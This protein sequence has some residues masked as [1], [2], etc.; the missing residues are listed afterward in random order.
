MKRSLGT[1]FGSNAFAM[2]GRLIAYAIARRMWTSVNGGTFQFIAS[3]PRMNDAG[4][5]YTFVPPPAVAWN[6]TGS[7]AGT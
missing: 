4:T 3:T 6:A 7:V 5:L 1:A 2:P